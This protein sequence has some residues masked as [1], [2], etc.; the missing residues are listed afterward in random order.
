AKSEKR[1]S[2]L[3]VGHT[4]RTKGGYQ[5]ALILV[6]N[7]YDTLFNGMLSGSS[8]QLF[9]HIIN[10]ISQAELAV[11]V[12]QSPLIRYFYEHLKDNIS[13]TIFQLEVY[14]N[15]RKDTN[16]YG[17]FPLGFSLKNL[18]RLNLSEAQRTEIIQI[19]HNCSIDLLPVLQT[20]KK[21][22]SIVSDDGMGDIK[23]KIDQLIRDLQKEAK[24]AKEND[25]FVFKEEDSQNFIDYE[26]YAIGE[27]Y[28]VIRPVNPM[29]GEPVGRTFTA[30]IFQEG[31]VYDEIDTDPNLSLEQLFEMDQPQNQELAHEDESLD[32]T[33]KIRFIPVNPQTGEKLVDEPISFEEYE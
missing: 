11:G 18:L 16:S 28:E 32:G 7:V 4:C 5:E 24:K 2:I 17:V 22:Q 3:Q 19:F 6:F 15:V 14:H 25:Y 9:P 27:N 31:D 13:Q 26:N 30:N 29:T 12:R 23:G 33:K 20:I 10:S 1:I 21:D 8:F